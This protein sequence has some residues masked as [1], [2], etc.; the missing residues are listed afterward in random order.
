[1]SKTIRWAFIVRGVAICSFI[2]FVLLPL[3]IY[4]LLS[5]VVAQPLYNKLIFQPTKYPTGDWSYA[6]ICGIKPKDADFKS[7]NGNNLHGLL[8]ELPGAQ[9]TV[10]LSQGSAYNCTDRRYLAEQFLQIG[11]S[12][13]VYDYSGYGKSTGEP[14]MQGICEDG[15]GALKYLTDVKKLPLNG[16]ILA[17][18]SLGTL[19]AGR[20]ASN[21]KCAG[22]ILLCPL[23][24]LRHTACDTFDFLN[25]YP[26]FA[27]SDAC[28][29]LDNLTALKNSTV[30]KLLISG[31]ADRLVKI[32]RSDELFATAA[33]PKTYIRIDGADH[34]DK[35]MM[36]YPGLRSGVK[37][38][39]ALL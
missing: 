9:K 26:D 10:L 2:I 21:Y 16:I 37:K 13:L 33:M 27:F 3:A 14:S 22:V 29:K 28:K 7:E 34:E 8:Y 30:P 1:M 38:F 32:K 20:L 4:V 36:E 24:S 17:G 39:I 23:S 19:V 5:P 31:T 15:T 12:I 25:Y 18:E 11:C 35:V 6:T